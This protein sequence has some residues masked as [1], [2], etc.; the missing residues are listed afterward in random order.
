MHL[1]CTKAAHRP[2]RH[3]NLSIL[4]LLAPPLST[5]PTT[6]AVLPRD[7]QEE[8]CFADQPR[9]CLRP[10]FPTHHSHRLH[11]LLI[12][13]AW[14]LRTVPPKTS[15]PRS[16][17]PPLS[18]SVPLLAL[19]HVA[20]NLIRP[21]AERSSGLHLSGLSPRRTGSCWSPQWTWTA[22]AARALLHQM[23]RRRRGTEGARSSK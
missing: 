20:R 9:R 18:A 8:A 11:R 21:L 1:G 7:G 3:P 5:R 4:P 10:I 15:N 22:R 19:G 14:A 12:L 17:S 16:L 23:R 13:H 6:R 2:H